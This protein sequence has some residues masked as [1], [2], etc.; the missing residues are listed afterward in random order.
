MPMFTN[1]HM[2]YNV[3][4]SVFVTCKETFESQTYLKRLKVSMQVHWDLIKVD[5]EIIRSRLL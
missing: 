1:G 5:L 2:I 4:R 3:F